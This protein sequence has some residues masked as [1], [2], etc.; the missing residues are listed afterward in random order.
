MVTDSSIVR[1]GKAF[2][3]I[4]LNSLS[5]SGSSVTI[6]KQRIRFE[7]CCFKKNN[8]LIYFATD[9][10]ILTVLIVPWI[11]TSVDNTSQKM[12]TMSL[13]NQK[14]YR[15]KCISI[16]INGKPTYGC[17]GRLHSL[18]FLIRW[19]IFCF[20]F[21]FILREKLHILGVLFETSF[22]FH[23][24]NWNVTWSHT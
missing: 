11:V 12:P 3:A 8:P 2:S 16:H 9:T 18:S 10:L 21:F 4:Q 23:T 13:G 14:H 15:Q 6:I 5:E 24:W 22:P 7:L 20:V 19:V 1:L 17:S